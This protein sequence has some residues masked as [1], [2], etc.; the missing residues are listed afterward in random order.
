M[1][2]GQPVW[3]TFLVN[4]FAAFSSHNGVALNIAGAIVLA[5]IAVGIFLPQPWTR[6]VVI[7][8]V[9]VAAF[10]WVVGEALGALF[11]GQGTDVNSGPLLA[12][13]AIAYWPAT[14]STTPSTGV[15]A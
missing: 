7:A 9:V 3:V 13:I 14:R 2:N 6:S 8:G 10:I 4:S 5:L 15:S 1:G 11:G 12:L